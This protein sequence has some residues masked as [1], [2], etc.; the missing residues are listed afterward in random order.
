MFCII[1]HFSS[2]ICFNAFL[3]I[4]LTQFSGVIAPFPVYIG[5]LFVN[6]IITNK[7]LMFCFW[8]AYDIILNVYF[9]CIVGFWRHEMLILF[10]FF[11]S[12]CFGFT[13]LGYLDVGSWNKKT[14]L[15]NFILFIFSYIFGFTGYLLLDVGGLVEN[16]QSTRKSILLLFIFLVQSNFHV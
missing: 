14:R 8:Q 3:Y 6:A 4:L 13:R 15:Y 12:L 2:S 16:N 1:G 10:S 11:F 9:L 5:I 7:V